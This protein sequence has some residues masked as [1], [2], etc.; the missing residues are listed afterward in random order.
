MEDCRVPIFLLQ[1]ENI[2]V[3]PSSLQ[4]LL[5]LL[6]GGKLSLSLYVCVLVVILGWGWWRHLLNNWLHI[7]QLCRQLI[8]NQ[9]DWVKASAKCTRASIS[10]II[11]KTASKFKAIHTSSSRGHRSNKETMLFVEHARDASPLHAATWRLNLPLKRHTT[12]LFAQRT[13][14]QAAEDSTL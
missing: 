12:I 7:L 8:Y 11:L 5:S 13:R 2:G 9:L 4:Q 14:R 6:M 3:D 10:D 1:K